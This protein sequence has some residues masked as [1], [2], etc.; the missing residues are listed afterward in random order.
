MKS[1]NVGAFTVAV[2]LCLTPISLRWSHGKDISSFSLSA[3]F[4]SAQAADLSLPVRHHR[5]GRYGYQAYSRLYNPYCDGPYTGGGWNGGAYYGGPW[6]DLRCY[7][8]VY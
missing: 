7:G 1:L 2:I 3:A 4:N 5:A 6:M 8:G